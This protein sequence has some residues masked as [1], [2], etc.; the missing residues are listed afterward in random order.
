MFKDMELTIEEKCFVLHAIAGLLFGAFAG[1]MGTGQ[2]ISF[3]GIAVMFVLKTVFWKVNDL[4]IKKYNTGWWFGNG[5]WP[6]FTLW[7]FAWV[8][9]YN[10]VTVA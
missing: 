7:L 4:D 10:L 2:W 6:Y 8:L 9:I 5:F 1:F 3:T